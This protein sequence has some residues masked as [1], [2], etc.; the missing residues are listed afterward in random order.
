MFFFFCRFLPQHTMVKNCKDQIWFEPKR[1][2]DPG[3]Q[4]PNNKFVED[5]IK[6]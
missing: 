1:G 5:G 3:P 4:S 6:S 2:M